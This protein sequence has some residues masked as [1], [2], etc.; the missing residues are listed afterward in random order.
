M[1]CRLVTRSRQPARNPSFIPPTGSEGAVRSFRA[2]GGHGLLIPIHWGVFDLAIHHW[3]QPI[4]Y[5][6]S[7]EGLKLLSPTPGA[8]SEVVPGQEIRSE[9]V[10]QNWRRCV[11]ACTFGFKLLSASQRSTCPYSILVAPSGGAV[12][13]Q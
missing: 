1:H 5:V 4:E 6:F 2:L 9:L 11:P 10:A 7:V 12:V 8:P 13:N 3:T